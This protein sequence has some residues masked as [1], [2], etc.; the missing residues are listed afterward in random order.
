[1][2]LSCP[3]EI[4]SLI[5]DHALEETFPIEEDLIDVS[6]IPRV[7]KD[8]YHRLP[9]HDYRVL[10]SVN[11]MFYSLLQ[12]RWHQTTVMEDH[13]QSIGIRGIPRSLHLQ[14]RSASIS[15]LDTFFP[16]PALSQITSLY[17]SGDFDSKFVDVLFSNGGHLS[18][19]HIFGLSLPPAFS[20]PGALFPG[21]SSAFP[22]LTR[23]SLHGDIKGSGCLQLEHLQFLDISY[24]H[25]LPTFVL[26]KLR[27]CS[28]DNGAGYCPLFI[29]FGESLHSLILFHN[30]YPPDP[31]LW[32]Y[33]RSFWDI[34]SDLRLL[35]LPF[36]LLSV[37]EPL[38]A[39]HPLHDLY[40][41]FH[42]AHEMYRF[43]PYTAES[44]IR[45]ITNAIENF[46]GIGRAII[47]TCHT[48][49][50]GSQATGIELAESD[51]RR[52][53]GL[54]NAKRVDVIWINEA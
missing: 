18:S 19:L 44:A 48:H 8:L 41:H 46:G 15:S 37:I 14:I 9:P 29:E 54:W 31:D 17:I 4:W 33:K 1:M 45:C 40:I 43:T 28:I 2:Y 20:Y 23:L 7:H 34:F 6:Q 30:S 52:L 16:G 35:G 24:S 27:H 21:L 10:R 12:N 3:P 51:C 11:K 38:P 47:N 22:H 39:D 50:D 5:L 32:L 53:T 26:P 42:R 49:R 36:A 25:E 13:S